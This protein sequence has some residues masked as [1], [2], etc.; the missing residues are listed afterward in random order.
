MNLNQTS[1]VCNSLLTEFYYDSERK[2]GSNNST[3]ILFDPLA[4]W[5]EEHRWY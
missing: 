5:E 1:T 2:F 3:Y 4:L